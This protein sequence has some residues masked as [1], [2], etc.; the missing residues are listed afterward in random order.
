MFTW[1]EDMKKATSL[2]V[3]PKDKIIPPSYK[4]YNNSSQTATTSI[5]STCST[6]TKM[7]I[8]L[9]KVYFLQKINLKLCQHEHLHNRDVL[10]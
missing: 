10:S 1:I 2:T 5:S 6:N 8:N 9:Q 3:Q 7:S 4:T